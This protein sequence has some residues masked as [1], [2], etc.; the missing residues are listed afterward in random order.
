MV[1]AKLDSWGLKITPVETQS[2][3]YATAQLKW[4]K[5]PEPLPFIYE[6]T[7]QI[8]RFT[9]THDPK[10]RSREVFTF[11][12]PETLLEWSR[13]PQSFHAALQNL[14]EL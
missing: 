13:Q 12:R 9:D 6:A 14:P 3:G 1:E 5:N 2:S 7:G 4:V 8:T 10:P 11:H